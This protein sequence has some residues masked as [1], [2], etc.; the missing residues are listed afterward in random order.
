MEKAVFKQMIGFINAN[1]ILSNFQ[2]GFCLLHST[3]FA[4]NFSNNLIS[5]CLNNNAVLTIFLDMTKAFDSL[6]QKILLFELHRY[7]FHGQVNN[8]FCSYLRDRS[9]TVYLNNSHSQPRLIM[10][11]VPQ[12][13][14][15]GPLLFLIYINDVFLDCGVK[16]VLCA[17]NAMIVIFGKSINEICCSANATLQLIYKRLT[18]NK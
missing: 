9:Q 8:W 6:N 3:S 17:N 14:I 15:L 10:Q 16:S 4:C 5:E 11:G 1:H 18:D 13:S 12:G 2:F 7:G